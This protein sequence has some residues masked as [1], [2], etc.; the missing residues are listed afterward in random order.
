MQEET[1]TKKGGKKVQTPYRVYL[2]AVGG[3]IVLIGAG[4]FGWMKY[5]A[6]NNTPAAQ[7]QKA[8]AAA[9]AEKKDVLGK[10]SK[11]MVLPEGDPVLFKVSDQ[12]QMRKQ[13]AFF[14]D[15]LNDDILLVFQASSKAIIY[16]PSTNVIVNVGP[17]NFDQA[18]DSKTSSAQV[19]ATAT[20]TKTTIKK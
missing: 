4:Y 10:L 6:M 12:E 5:Q 8:A 1:T 14:K 16:R 11:L 17:I 3:L 7:E 19:P 13:Q 2:I 20:N 15:A 18:K 9:D